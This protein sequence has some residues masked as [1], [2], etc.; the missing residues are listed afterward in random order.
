MTAGAIGAAAGA[1]ASGLS[2]SREACR[3]VVRLRARNFYYG[4]RLTPEPKRSALYAVYAWM[5]V[6]DDLVDGDAGPRLSAS[7]RRGALA[8]F[9]SRTRMVLSGGGAGGVGDDGGWLGVSACWPCWEALGDAV[10]RYG[11]EESDFGAVIEALGVDLAAQRDGAEGG[12]PR[13]LFE[14]MG[15]LE[16][17]CRGVAS[18]VGV[19]CVRV[20]G[21]HGGED[22]GRVRELASRRGLAFQLTNV[23][24][25][26][27]EDAGMGRCY[28]PR[29]LLCLCGLESGALSRW[30]DP[31]ACTALV[32]ALVRETRS[33]YAASAELD[34]LVHRDGA[35]TLWAM[36]RIYRGVLERVAREPRLSLGGGGGARLSGP[37]KAGIAAAAVVRSAAGVR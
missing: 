15:G 7:D 20:W 1:G 5:R 36:T 28:V 18:A 21:H 17:Y 32:E 9:W 3:R 25:D 13:V 34:R 6:A 2:G 11:L 35:A 22:W 4:L 24:R 33:H 19:I 14:T 10:E 16:R 30:E 23:L 29:E 37:A 12:S 31:R 26:I 27:G 8:A